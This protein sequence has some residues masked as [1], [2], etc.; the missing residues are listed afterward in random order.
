MVEKFKTIKVTMSWLHLP[1]RTPLPPLAPPPLY[2]SLAPFLKQ[3]G[4]SEQLSPIYEICMDCA[5]FWLCV[6]LGHV[7]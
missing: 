3:I 7:N 2:N 5:S 6:V 4:N 1:Q